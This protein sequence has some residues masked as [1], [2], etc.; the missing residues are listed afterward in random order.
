M[1]RS[2]RTHV[3]P[4][5]PGVSKQGMA[6]NK[7]HAVPSTKACKLLSCFGRGT[8]WVAA[9]EP[10]LQT[11]SHTSRML[12]CSV[13]QIQKLLCSKSQKQLSKLLIK[14]DTARL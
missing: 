4:P 13:T 14:D 12:A 8:M 1:G 6:A 2:S 9:T 7:L 10:Q 5:P 11:H 3:D